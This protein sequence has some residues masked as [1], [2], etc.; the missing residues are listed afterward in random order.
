MDS[1]FTSGLIRVVCE[2]ELTL[3]VHT[4]M[5]K[6]ID[7]TH[8]RNILQPWDMRRKEFQRSPFFFLGGGGGL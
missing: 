6:F 4:A 2:P 5:K 8:Y 1:G 7:L 3:E